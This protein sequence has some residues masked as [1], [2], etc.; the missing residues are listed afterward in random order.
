MSLAANKQKYSKIGTVSMSFFALVNGSRAV[1]LCVTR[2]KV[3]V[4]QINTGRG[5]LARNKKT[6]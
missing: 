6:Y 3:G 2:L 1:D 5:S 4:Y